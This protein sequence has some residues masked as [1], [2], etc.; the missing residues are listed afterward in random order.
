MITEDEI[1]HQNN[2]FFDLS[3][4]SLQGPQPDGPGEKD[5]DN[6]PAHAVQQHRDE[7]C[8]GHYGGRFTSPHHPRHN[9]HDPTTTIQTRPR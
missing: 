7:G 4:P 3:H 6:R 5:V 1:S 8:Q 2:N 9:R